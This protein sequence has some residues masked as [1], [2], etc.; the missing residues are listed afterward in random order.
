[1]YMSSTCS[2]TF[3]TWSMFC[4]HDNCHSQGLH[5]CP[6]RGSEWSCP[7]SLM[8][9][10]CSWKQPLSVVLSAQ[11]LPYQQ[12]YGYMENTIAIWRIRLSHPLTLPARWHVLL[13]VWHQCRQFLSSWPLP[14]FLLS[15]GHNRPWTVHASFV[16]LCPPLHSTIRFL[17]STQE[18]TNFGGS[19]Q[20]GAL[21]PWPWTLMY[22]GKNINVTVPADNLDKYLSIWN[23]GNSTLQVVIEAFLF[24]TSL[25][26]LRCVHW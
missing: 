1:M 8:A 24:R 3:M 14:S 15:S 16:K 26:H 4:H 22:T 20:Q 6:C 9:R 11:H 21:Q 7:P 19:I 23:L 17:V 12:R 18:T 13:C 25:A 5:L 10:P 2:S